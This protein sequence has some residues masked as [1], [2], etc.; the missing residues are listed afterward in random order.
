[1]Q[2]EAIDFLKTLPEHR[3][4]LIL[5][6]FRVAVSDAEIYD[7]LVSVMDISDDEMF[8]VRDLVYKFLGAPNYD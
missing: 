3:L 8:E 2:V 4:L 7:N 1:M 6:A 5:E